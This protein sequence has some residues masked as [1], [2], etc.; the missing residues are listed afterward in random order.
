MIIPTDIKAETF[1]NYLQG[2]LESVNI[3]GMHKRNA[4]GDILTVSETS[5]GIKCDVARD[6]IYDILP[7]ALFH[8][9]DRFDNIPANEY[10]ERFYEE[11]EQQQIEEANARNFFAPFDRYLMT[12]NQKIDTLR[13]AGI[14]DESIISELFLDRLP[15]KFRLNRFVNRVVPYLPLC[16]KIRGD[17]TMIS[18]MIRRIL[19]DEGVQLE[20]YNIES[21]FEDTN[22]K[23]CC[24]IQ[25]PD[26]ENSDLYLGSSFEESVSEYTVKYWNEGECGEGFLQFIDEMKIF[27]EFIN[28]FFIGIESSLTF[29]IVT[30]TLQVRLSDTIYHNFLGYNTNL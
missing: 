30:Q 4:Y 23:Y 8:S 26:E 24:S 9:I 21:T 5:V 19:F 18:L 28:D 25:N 22:P 12:I 2:Y 10:K 17:R 13:E 20:M 27:E 11:Y 3:N 14:Y 15:D 29:N 1:L 16:S 7:E 6:G